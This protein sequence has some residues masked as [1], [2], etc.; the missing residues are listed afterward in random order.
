MIKKEI[1]VKTSSARSE[2]DVRENVAIGY[3][4]AHQ[5]DSMM[6]LFSFNPSP[7]TVTSI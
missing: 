1:K 5:L 4:S 3:S 6:R 2:G 7:L